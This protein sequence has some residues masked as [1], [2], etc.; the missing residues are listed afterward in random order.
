MTNEYKSK[1]TK[2]TKYLRDSICRQIIKDSFDSQFA[3]IEAERKVF[4]LKVYDDIYSG[5]T[6][7]AMDAL[8]SGWLPESDEFYVQ[9]GADGSGYCRRAFDSPKRF[10]GKD[11]ITRTQCLKVYDTGHPLTHEHEDLTNK[12]NDLRAKKDKAIQQA[13]A[14]LESCTTTK[15]L[16]ELWVEIAKYVE[17]YEPT[18]E[19]TTAVALVTDELNELLNLKRD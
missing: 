3:E 14:V 16:K 6:R 12:L 11:V 15:Q 13:M 5:E 2:L 4:S 1:S 7:Q 17:Q 8:P 10:L 9:F 19:R 18:E